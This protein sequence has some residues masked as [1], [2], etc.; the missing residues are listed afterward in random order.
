MDGLTKELARYK[1]VTD[2]LPVNETELQWIALQLRKLRESITQDAL[3][4][5]REWK[6]VTHE[7]D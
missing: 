2:R 1:A 4:I 6:R 7:S 3:D 5:V